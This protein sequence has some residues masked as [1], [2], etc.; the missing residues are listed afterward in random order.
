MLW[1]VLAA[2]EKNSIK[3]ANTLNLPTQVFIHN[4][5]IIDKTDF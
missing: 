5:I 1:A 4:H 3:L 2:L